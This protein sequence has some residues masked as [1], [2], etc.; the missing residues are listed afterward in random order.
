MLA[1]LHPALT[2]P[3]EALQGMPDGRQ[4][5]EHRAVVHPTAWSA[6][7]CLLGLIPF[8][9]LFEQALIRSAELAPAESLAWP[10]AVVVL[11][12]KIAVPIGF[13]RFSTD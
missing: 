2:R 12:Q 7:H 13:G 9:W 5:V 4:G 10:Q 3:A 11:V 8:A 6:P 1:L